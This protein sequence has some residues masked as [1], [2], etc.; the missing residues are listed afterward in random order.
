LT[1]SRIKDQL[2]V[3]P[4]SDPGSHLS[5]DTL[6]LALPAFTFVLA[7]RSKTSVTNKVTG[8]HFMV[9]RSSNLPAQLLALGIRQDMWYKA[10]RDTGIPPA[11]KTGMT[12]RFFHIPGLTR[13]RIND[14]L[15]VIP[16]SDPGSRLS[17]D[18]FSLALA[19][20]YFLLWQKKTKTKGRNNHSHRFFVPA[21]LQGRQGLPPGSI[22][23]YES[24]RIDVASCWQ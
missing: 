18:T 24:E 11:A 19:A 6:G 5:R 2:H 13:S 16:D 15:H 10:K 1:R 20:V 17:R 23:K 3:I 22:A 4:D 9:S 7:K 21:T 14:Q 8:M 12:Y